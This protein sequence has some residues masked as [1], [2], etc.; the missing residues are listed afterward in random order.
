MKSKLHYIS[1]LLL[2][3]HVSCNLSKGT[4]DKQKPNV[5]F[6]L[7]DDLGWKDLGCYGSEVYET[8]GIDKLAAD[9]IR[10]TNAYA[11]HPMCLPSRVAIMSGKYPSRLG[12]PGGKHGKGHSPLPLEEVT[13]AEALKQHEYHTFFAGKWHIGKENAYPQHQGFD[14]NLGGHAKGEPATYF[15]PYQIGDKVTNVPDLEGGEEGE[16]LTDRLTDETIRFIKQKKDQPF[17]VFLSHYAVHIP[18]EAKDSL[19]KYYQAKMDTFNFRGEAWQEEGPA[20]RKMHQDNPIYAAMVASVDES[21]QRIRNTLID[22]ELDD[23]TIIVFT[24]DNGGDAC[25]KNQNGYSTSNVPLRAGKC[26]MYD[27]GIRV[28]LIVYQPGSKMN[29]SV[30]EHLSTGV[31]HYPSILEMTGMP[32]LPDQHVD[33]ISYARVLNEQEVPPRKPIFWHFPNLTL[34]DWVVGSENASAIFDGEYKLIEYLDNDYTEMYNLKEDIS[35][36]H[37]LVGSLP[38]KTEELYNQLLQWRN[39]VN[40]PAPMLPKK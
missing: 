27:G 33:G 15:Y 2:L 20:D 1:I 18:L 40:A 5:V 13:I 31:D 25:K 29:G 34:F 21:V 36:S 11:A 16:Y 10:F 39:E 4:K 38:A 12:V 17:F 23:N 3:G 37:N 9:G 7:I 24:A 28:P 19:L 26:W 8:P 14:I 32:L 22:L 30:S 6:F 35:E